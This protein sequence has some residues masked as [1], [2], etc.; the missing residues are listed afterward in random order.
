MESFKEG[1]HFTEGLY[2]FW[3]PT[4]GCMA[5]AIGDGSSA[6]RKLVCPSRITPAWSASGGLSSPDAFYGDWASSGSMPIR[7]LTA[8]RNFCLHPR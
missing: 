2:V 8:Q 7:S 6:T 5:K 1:S 3:I 4:T